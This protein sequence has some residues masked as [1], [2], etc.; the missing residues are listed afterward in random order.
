M[1]CIS[2][3]EQ[4]FV[5]CKHIHEHINTNNSF[6]SGGNP[7]VANSTE[8]ILDTSINNEVSNNLQ[9]ESGTHNDTENNDNAG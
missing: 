7:D 3:I 4:I 1:I 8:F 2:T 6:T 9:N 5:L